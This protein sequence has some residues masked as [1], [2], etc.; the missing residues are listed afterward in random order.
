M[1]DEWETPT[2]F[3]ALRRGR[4]HPITHIMLS[5]SCSADLTRPG[6]RDVAAVAARSLKSRSPTRLRRSCLAPSERRR[7]FPNPG[8]PGQQT[9]GALLAKWPVRPW[10]G[11]KNNRHPPGQMARPSVAGPTT[12][13]AI[14]GGR[15]RPSLDGHENQINPMSEP[16]GALLAKWPVPPWTGKQPAASMPTPDVRPCPPAADSRHAPR[17]APFGRAARNMPSIGPLSGLILYI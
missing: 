10:T 9:S 12:K 1:T 13:S 4:Q 15:A 16:T 11:T 8:R 5:A 6:Y 7:H 17:G 3:S 14:H 2:D